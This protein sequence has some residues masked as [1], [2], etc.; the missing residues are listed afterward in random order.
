MTDADPV[1]LT[2]YSHGAGCGC[3]IAPALLDEILAGG[4]AGP[5]AGLLVGNH[6]RDDAA[7][8]DLGDG[9]AL[10]STTDFFMPVVDDAYTFGR[11]AAANALS[12]VYA[13]GGTPVLAVAILG[14]PVDRL[15][16][17]VAAAVVAGGRATCAEAGI[18]LAGGHSI[19]SP[20]PLF[21]LA[22]NGLVEVAHVKRNSTAQPGDLLFLTK[23]LGVGLLTTAQKR[24]LLQPAD[25]G[26]AAAHMTRLNAVGARLGPLAGV[27]AL[28]DVTGFGLL[29]HLAELCQG[30]GVRAVVEAAAVPTITDLAPYLEAGTVPGGTHRNWQSYGHLVGP[31]PEALRLVLCDPQTSGGLLVAAAPEAV[32]AMREA[33][34]AEAAAFARP[35]GRV[36]PPAPGAPL[37]T[38]EG[39]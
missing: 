38:V 3:K 10:I 18:A 31:L 4:L 6:T 17:A 28:T 29:G 9:R 22:V 37:I 32:A 33:A 2:Q 35:I 24:G 19:D 25:A 16:A 34:R 11:V 12:D 23:P 15:P 14:W 5:A 7:V 1:R 8:L 13:M 20:E 21:G 36:L 30:S 26:L 39:P 27:H